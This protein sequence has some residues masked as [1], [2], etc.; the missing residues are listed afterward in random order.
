MTPELKDFTSE[1]IKFLEQKHGSEKFNKL[2][3]PQNSLKGGC[4]NRVK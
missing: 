4:N 3:F 2:Y 1:E